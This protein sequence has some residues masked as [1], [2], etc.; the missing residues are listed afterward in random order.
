M[1]GLHIAFTGVDGA[2][3]S[4]QAVRLCRRLGAEGFVANLV[5]DKGTFGIDLLRS[6]AARHGQ[7]PRPYFGHRV[8]DVVKALE[9]LR[10]NAERIR[11]LVERGEIAVVPRSGFCRLAIAAIEDPESVPLVDAIVHLAGRP[12]LVLFL[13]TPPEEC[14]ARVEARGE[15][16]RV[17][18][19]SAFAERLREVARSGRVMR[20][21][22][23]AS[24]DEVHERVWNAL[25]PT[26][27]R[28]R[29]GLRI[30]GPV[31]GPATWV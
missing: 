3:K 1:R 16:G 11:P 27:L 9:M 10:D 19:L 8:T 4:T 24:A 31:E 7:A 22:G 30:A 28:R 29:D 26:L 18:E 21:A 6:V 20:I 2:G 5:E 25:R 12:D 14:L 17:D 15:Q 13:D 23:D